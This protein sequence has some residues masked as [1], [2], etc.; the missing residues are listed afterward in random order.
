MQGFGVTNKEVL[1]EQVNTI[2][3]NILCLQYYLRFFNNRFTI[4]YFHRMQ[5]YNFIPKGTT[6]SAKQQSC[7]N[8][9]Y[10]SAGVSVIIVIVGTILNLLI[11]KRKHRKYQHLHKRI[12]ILTNVFCNICNANLILKRKS[13]PQTFCIIKKKNSPTFL[14]INFL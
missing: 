9:I 3:L 2:N 4:Y 8:S 10:I 6:L 11:W 7:K 5:S 13:Y 14:K 12:P 1:I